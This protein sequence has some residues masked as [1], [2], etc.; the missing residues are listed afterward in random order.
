MDSV[1][2]TGYTTSQLRHWLQQLGLP[3]TGTKNTLLIRLNEVPADKRGECPM[4]ADE[5]P[6]DNDC[7]EVEDESRPNNNDRNT[8]ENECGKENDRMQQNEVN[9]RAVTGNVEMRDFVSDLLRKELDLIKREKELLH[10][11]NEVLK[12]IV[13]SEKKR[14]TVEKAEDAEKYIAEEELPTTS[15]ATK[16]EMKVSFNILKEMIPEY[17]DTMLPEM[18]IE[19]FKNITKAYNADGC[20]IKTLLMCKLKGKAQIWL[21]LK[22]NFVNESAENILEHM[23]E[24]FCTKENKLAMRRKFEARKWKYEEHFIDYYN[25]KVMLSGKIGIE[26]DELIDQIIEGIPD[27]QLRIQAS[28]QCYT[29]KTQLLQAFSKIELKQPKQFRRKGD[30]TYEEKDNKFRCYN[31]NSIGH[32]AAD[33][34][35]PKRQMGACYGCNSMDHRVADCPERKKAVQH[36]AEDEYNA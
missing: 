1:C 36:V 33:C 19:Q 29:S 34:Q 4:E 32:F 27:Y 25:E 7:V 23:K 6:G 8:S 5:P 17:D 18:W 35:K 26:D 28:L 10:R 3:S 11:E 30:Q 21:H 15:K 22:P 24:N 20:T 13:E 2:G 16:N 12:L 14:Q 9:D 31:C